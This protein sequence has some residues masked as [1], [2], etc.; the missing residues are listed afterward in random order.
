LGRTE[1]ERLG[2]NILSHLE[3]VSRVFSSVA[4]SEYLTKVTKQDRTAT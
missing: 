1:L 2:K 4:A 3:K